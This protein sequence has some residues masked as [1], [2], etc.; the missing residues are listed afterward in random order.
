[1][2]SGRKDDDEADDNLKSLHFIGTK[3]QEKK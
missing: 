3:K 2:D 1:M